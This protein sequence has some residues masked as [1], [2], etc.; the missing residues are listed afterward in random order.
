MAVVPLLFL[1][2]LNCCFRPNPALALSFHRPLV[3]G[4]WTPPGA[5]LYPPSHA[6]FLSGRHQK[7]ATQWNGA[8][9][10]ACIVLPCPL[11]GTLVCP[12]HRWR[13]IWESLYPLRSR[14]LHF[15]VFA[16]D[17]LQ[18]LCSGQVLCYHRLCVL[19]QLCCGI[20]RLHHGLDIGGLQRSMP[21]RH[22]RII[23]QQCMHHMSS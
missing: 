1:R 12:V 19:Y 11:V 22:L 18:R 3:V 6:L 7:H 17:V 21:T 10:R 15:S 20:V 14:H 23:R 13:S 4:R 16:R 8:S 5:P 9:R 2:T